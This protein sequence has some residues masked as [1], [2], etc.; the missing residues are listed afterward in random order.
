MGGTKIKKACFTVNV[1]LRKKWKREKT[2]N[3]SRKRREIV[4]YSVRDDVE[5]KRRMCSE[6]PNVENGVFP[7]NAVSGSS[8]Q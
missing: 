4:E 3:I 2:D 6:K 8:A 5:K 1:A 7:A